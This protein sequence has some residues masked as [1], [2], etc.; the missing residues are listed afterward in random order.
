MFDSVRTRLTFWYVGVLTLVLV[1]FSFGVYA[2]LAGNLERRTDAGLHAALD[3]MKHLLGYERA[4]GDSELEAAR[5]TVAELRYPHM[6]LAVYT[7]DG[8]LLAETLAEG[9]LHATLP[10]APSDVHETL[11]LLTRPDARTT[12]EDRLRVAVQRVRALPTDAPNLIVALQSLETMNEELTSLRQVFLVAVPLALALAGLGGWFLARKALTPVVSMSEQARRISA[13]NLEERL[14][15]ANPRDE[16]GRLAGTFNELLARLNVSFDQQRQFMADASHELRT[17]LSVMHT[18]AEVTLQRAHRAESEYRDALVLM[19]AQTQRLAR[20]VT[21]M[22]TLARADAGHRPIE[23]TDFYLDEL[24]AET[25]RAAQVLGERSGVKVSVEP[26]AETIFHGDEGLLRQM[27]LNLLDNSIKHTP[28]GGQVSITLA[29]RDGVIEFVVA[30]SGSG[31]PL[32]AQPHI[33]ER[34]YRVDEAR[35][36]SVQ[37][38]A[39]V[40]GKSSGAGLGLSIARW[41]AEAHGGSISLVQSDPAGTTFSVEL[42]LRETS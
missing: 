41:V 29:Q 6:A 38:G 27:L 31:I 7:A 26:C 36:R 24:L 10:L 22:F 4:E 3:S 13:S 23:P 19:D 21:D 5:N 8:Q 18:T 15:V 40:N 42:P 25:V 28:S 37:N 11:R 14:P 33:F 16:L 9:D 1:A 2:L 34:F 30:D 12:K 17:P 20:I 32:E 35:S 39:T